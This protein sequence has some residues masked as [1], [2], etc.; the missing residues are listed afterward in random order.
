M[1]IFLK[2]NHINMQNICIYAI[3]A[4]TLQPQFCKIK[5]VVS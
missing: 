1:Q 2:K 4:V 5:H 3:F